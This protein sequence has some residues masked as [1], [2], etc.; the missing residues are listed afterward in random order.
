MNQ[1]DGAARGVVTYLEALD[2]LCP[3]DVAVLIGVE[4]VEDNAEFLSRE[5]DAELRHHFF[6]FQ[7][8]KDSILICVKL[9]QI[10]SIKIK[11]L[12]NLNLRNAV[13]MVPQR[14]HL[15]RKRL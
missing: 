1:L 8:V 4:G 11:V 13:K 10:G 6:K 3:G 2:E 9:L 5:E 7:F 12:N 15:H 14:W